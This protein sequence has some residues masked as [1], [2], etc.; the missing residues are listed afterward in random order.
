MPETHKIEAAQSLHK[1]L[2]N[3]T[4]AAVR[5]DTGVYFGYFD[6]DTGFLLN[7]TMEYRQRKQVTNNQITFI[8]NDITT[9]CYLVEN[10][11]FS[12]QLNE[13]DYILQ[14]QTK[15]GTPYAITSGSYRNQ[16]CIFVGFKGKM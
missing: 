6:L 16:V 3:V 10:S 8:D 2:A 4:V 7:K 1:G 11:L 5:S 9:A 15:D 13:I 14:H 12:W